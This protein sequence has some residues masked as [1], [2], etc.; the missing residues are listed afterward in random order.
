MFYNIGCTHNLRHIVFYNEQIAG[1]GLL[2][3]GK[4]KQR[5]HHFFRIHAALQADF[6]FHLVGRKI[7]NRRD[8]Y[9]AAF[10]RRFDGLHKRFGIAAGGKFGN[11]NALGIACVEFCARYDFSQSVLIIGHVDE[12]AGR[13][14]RI[15]LK[16]LSGKAGFF[17]FDY[18]AD[19]VA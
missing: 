2:A 17:G 16:G 5:V 6:D 15:Q 18:F 8:F 19:I 3:V 1:N 14:I 13:K 9:L 4:G 7:V 10:C 11:Y 12:A